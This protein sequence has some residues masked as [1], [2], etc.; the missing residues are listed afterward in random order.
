M[1]GVGDSSA[2]VE[3]LPDLV[4]TYTCYTTFPIAQTP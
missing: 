1:G 2:G 3:H 4:Y